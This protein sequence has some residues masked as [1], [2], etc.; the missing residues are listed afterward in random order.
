MPFNPGLSCLCHVIVVCECCCWCLTQCWWRMLLIVVMQDNPWCSSV[1][2]VSVV[3]VASVAPRL[4]VCF[5]IANVAPST[6]L[7]LHPVLL[8]KILD[9]PGL[10][11]LYVYCDCCS[12]CWRSTQCWWRRCPRCCSWW[13]RTT[14]AC[15]V[16]TCPAPSSSSWCTPAP[17]C[18]LS[19]ASSSTPTSNRPSGQTRWMECLPVLH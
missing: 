19:R 2:H 18:F 5:F 10:L 9:V 1:C 11:Q 16:S 7:M 12:C 17:M 15:H 8:E 14:Q 4:C 3:F 13:C 6:D